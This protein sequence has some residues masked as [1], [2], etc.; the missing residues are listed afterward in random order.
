MMEKL[1]YTIDEAAKLIGCSRNLA[2]RLCREGKFPGVIKLGDKRMVVS[3]KSIEL[4]L[5][6][7][8]EADGVK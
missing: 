7:G 5:N 1:T 2:Y 6:R 8:S 4:L 3:K